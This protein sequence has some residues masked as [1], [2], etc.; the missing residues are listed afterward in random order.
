MLYTPLLFACKTK[1]K[2]F[3]GIINF[4]KLSIDSF[5]IPDFSML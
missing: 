3:F 4:L 1:C 2:Y 5:D